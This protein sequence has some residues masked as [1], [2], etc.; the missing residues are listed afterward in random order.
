[1]RGKFSAVCEARGKAFFFDLDLFLRPVF[2][3]RRGI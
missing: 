2:K 3:E 1:M